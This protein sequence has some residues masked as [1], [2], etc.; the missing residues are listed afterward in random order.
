MQL[1]H[2]S[3]SLP[4]YHQK[5]P[6]NSQPPLINQFH[7]SQYHFIASSVLTSRTFI[8]E[9]IYGTHI[10]VKVIGFSRKNVP[11]I[12]KNEKVKFLLAN[13]SK[14]HIQYYIECESSNALIF[15]FFLLL[16]FF[17]FIEFK[18]LAPNICKKSCLFWP[19]RKLGTSEI[20]KISDFFLSFLNPSFRFLL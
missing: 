7:H 6:N 5:S 4:L 19:G 2:Q 9:Q 10:A 8:G 15:F 3:T 12:M 20:S 1:V 17:A 18:I 11:N 16:L 14:S 13:V